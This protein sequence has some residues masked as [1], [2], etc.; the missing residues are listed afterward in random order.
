MVAENSV[1]EPPL[2]A[3]QRWL[4]SEVMA[5]GSLDSWFEPLITLTRPPVETE[6]SM[7]EL[8]LAAHMWP[9]PEVMAL[10]A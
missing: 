3:T 10:G 1:R 2:S 8:S 9:P 5:D 4:P 6:S 7:T